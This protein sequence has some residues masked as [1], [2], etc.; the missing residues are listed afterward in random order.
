MFNSKMNWFI[1]T[2]FVSFRGV[3]DDSYVT[4][5][6]VIASVFLGFVVCCMML[7]LLAL[8]KRLS[9]VRRTCKRAPRL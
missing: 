8:G 4:I 3:A 1:N 5:E 9:E 6:L 7:S 2:I